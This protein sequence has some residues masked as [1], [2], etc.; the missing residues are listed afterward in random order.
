MYQINIIDNYNSFISARNGPFSITKDNV[1]KENGQPSKNDI[2]DVIDDLKL[3]ANKSLAQLKEE[4]PNLLIFPEDLSYYQDGLSDKEKTL[5]SLYPK[6]SYGF[7]ETGNV[8]GWIGC[9]NTQLKI[10]SRFDSDSTSSKKYQITPKKDFFMLYLLSQVGEFHLTAFDYSEGDDSPLDSLIMLMLPECLENAIG[11][12]LYK[13]YHTFDRN[14]ANVRGSINISRHIQQNLPFVGKVAYRSR[15]YSFDNDMTQ[16]IRHTLEY[17]KEKPIGR[18]LL[19]GNSDIKQCVDM[20]YQATPTYETKN[21]GRVINNN[22]RPKV[23][24]C[25]T[26]YITLQKLCLQ[27]L[28]EEGINYGIES[29]EK[30]HGILFD[31]AWLWEAYINRLLV[32]ANLGFIHPDNIA[33]KNAY[34]I[35]K[36][37]DNTVSTICKDNR[38]AYPDFYNDHCV[39]DAKYKHL[40]NKV[41]REDLFQVISYMHTMP[42]D[43]G[44]YIYPYQIQ[45]NENY[46]S[47]KIFHLNGRND[48]GGWIF[49]IPFLIPSYDM[50]TTWDKFE[51]EIKNEEKEFIKKLSSLYLQLQNKRDIE[52]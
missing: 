2:L 8:M 3:V 44:G 14:D 13:E 21:R 12:G 32:G 34:K 1:I 20:I 6:S 42:R 46:P 22:L 50:N 10:Y 30:V 7:M 39:L 43:V 38:D 45:Q 11:Q 5:F 23:H 9:G 47:E 35:F 28:H 40:E 19:N 4:N 37:N 51:N 25:Y 17:M 48:D 15:E 24:P 26:G 16:L 41:Q 49:T 18:S 33:R 27:I 29:D 52:K 36:T 31:G